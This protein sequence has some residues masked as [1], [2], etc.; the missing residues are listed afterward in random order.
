[1]S[2]QQP[3]ATITAASTTVSRAYPSHRGVTRNRHTTKPY[4]GGAQPA[5][6]GSHRSRPSRQPPGVSRNA[7][8]RPASSA[9]WSGHGKTAVAVGLLSAFAARGFR[10]GGFKVGPDHVDAAYLGLAAGRQGRNLDPRLVG[11]SRVGP[12][13]AHGAAGLDIA[14]IEG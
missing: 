5:S 7:S 2:C 1:S 6:S 9:P 4:P 14:V 10:T 3:R 12:L 8:A 11:A 13:F